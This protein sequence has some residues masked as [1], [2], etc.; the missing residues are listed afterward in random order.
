MIE[1]PPHLLATEDRNG[2][3]FSYYFGRYI[4]EGE[5][6]REILKY[7]RIEGLDQTLDYGCHIGG[8]IW[9][10]AELNKNAKGIDINDVYVNIC[11][12]I[13]AYNKMTNIAAYASDSLTN[14]EDE[15]MDAIITIGTLQVVQTGDLWHDFFEKAHRAVKS[16]GVVLFNYALPTM[17]QDYYKSKEAFDYIDQKGEKWCKQRHKMWKNIY[18]EG[19]KCKKIKRGKTYYA[20]P[21]D[22]AVKFVQD[23]GWDIAVMPED[24]SQNTRV[25]E[26]ESYP[27]KG[28]GLRHYDFILL[29]K[30]L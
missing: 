16:G 1:L 19:R 21:R 20:V 8:W 30:P 5:I 6:V 17:A 9:Y 29:R 25:D 4:R 22:T 24:F 15:A 27:N 13:A 28:D 10:L 14:L 26:M 18:N 7:A 3:P 11:N 2:T 12:E 23:K